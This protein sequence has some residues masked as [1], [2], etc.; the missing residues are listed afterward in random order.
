MGGRI[1]IVETD[2]KKLMSS[3]EFIGAI[4]EEYLRRKNRSA[5]PTQ[6]TTCSASAS[7]SL[8]DRLQHDSSKSSNV[9]FRKCRNCGFTNH[10]TDDCRWLGQPKCTKCG[11]FG[12]V[13]SECTQGEKRKNEKNGQK[14]KP[15]FKRAKKERVNQA[16]EESSKDVTFTAEEIDGAY[17]FDS[18]DPLNAEGN[19][20][21]LLFYDWLA[22]SC[23]TSH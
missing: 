21:R 4:K 14:N 20:E 2:P 13:A 5:L 7:H 3:Q 22:D 6:Q 10:I 18:Y 19:D 11:W 1:D 16:A 9:P 17:N 15:K 8:M 23:T 12:H